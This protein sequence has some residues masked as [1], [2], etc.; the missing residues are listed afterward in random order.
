MKYLFI[1]IMLLFLNFKLSAQNKITLYFDFNKQELNI[2]ELEKFKF[3]LSENKD[4]K[5]IK[6][7][8]SA[9]KKGESNYNTKLVQKRIDFVMTIIGKNI[10][11][12]TKFQK[13]NL[14]ENTTTLEE[15]AL[16]RN[17]QIFFLTSRE[18]RYEELIL[19]NLQVKEKLQNINLKKDTSDKKLLLEDKLNKA[20]IGTYFS[21]DNIQFEMD[22]EK[23]FDASKVELKKWIS[24]LKDNPNLKIIVQGHICCVPRDDFYLSTRRAKQVVKFFND[25]GINLDRLFYIGY[26]AEKPIYKIPER[27]GLEAKMN[28]R[29]EIVILEK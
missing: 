6:I 17:V 12:D 3:W 27:N 28:R 7:T 1:Y 14:G 23:L 15:D 13:F 8:G 19:N 18:Q 21:F 10:L 4:I 9:D 16:Q 2:E 24:V 22:S 29:I 26:G 5:I 11:F 20:E 25:N